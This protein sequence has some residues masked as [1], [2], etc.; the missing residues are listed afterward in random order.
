MRTRGGTCLLD[1]ACEYGDVWWPCARLLSGPSDPEPSRGSAGS[2]ARAGPKAVG[3]DRS[4]AP[5]QLPPGPANSLG[6]TS[7]A[8]GGSLP[9]DSQGLPFLP[10]PEVGLGTG[11]SGL[12]PGGRGL[13]VR[14]AGA[15]GSRCMGFRAG[16]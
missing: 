10:L 1:G 13:R 4:V 16:R 2:G 7:T 15:A 14:S 8:P 6:L 12:G 11:E 9:A 3:P 5:G